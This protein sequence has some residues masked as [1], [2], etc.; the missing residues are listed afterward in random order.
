MATHRKRRHISRTQVQTVDSTES[1]LMPFPALIGLASGFLVFFL[2]AMVVFATRPHPLHWLIAA[3]G[4][5]LFYLVGLFYAR[6]KA[7][8]P[9]R[10]ARS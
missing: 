5:A 4:G 7:A 9:H 10:K 3:G 2:G 1:D 8:H 6:H